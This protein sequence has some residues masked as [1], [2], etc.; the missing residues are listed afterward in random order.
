MQRPPTSGDGKGLT[1]TIWTTSPDVNMSAGEIP[2]LYELKSINSDTA[3]TAFLF[4]SPG[5]VIKQARGS[6]KPFAG[7]EVIGSPKPTSAMVVEYPSKNSWGVAVWSLKNTSG[8]T[9]EF[10]GQP[11]M[12]YWGS[13]DRWK[14]VLPTVS[15]TISILR[16]SS[17]VS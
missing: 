4:G 8:P 2:G 6:F 15:N 17:A 13:T 9:L 1:T 10:A 12:K 14:V 16:E 7:W 11:Y 5:M 3:L